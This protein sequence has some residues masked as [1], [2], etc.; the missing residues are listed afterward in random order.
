MDTFRL[1]NRSAEEVEEMA[2]ELR[3]IRPRFGAGD[4]AA[5]LGV[6]HAS[7]YHWITGDSVP[8]PALAR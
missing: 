1:R 2:D 6:T 5:T 7:I 8:H 4:L 3:Q